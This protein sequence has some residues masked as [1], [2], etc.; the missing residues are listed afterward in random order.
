MHGEDYIYDL[1]PNV[2][3]HCI[4]IYAEQISDFCLEFKTE[5]V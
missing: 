1:F 2:V 3:V 4:S 5:L